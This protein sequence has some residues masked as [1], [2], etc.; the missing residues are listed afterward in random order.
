MRWAS[1]RIFDVGLWASQ[2]SDHLGSYIL[3]DHRIRTSGGHGILCFER[4]SRRWK[5]PDSLSI[6][7][8]V[9][10][11]LHTS[12]N[13]PAMDGVAA[14]TGVDLDIGQFGTPLVSSW[15]CWEIP[16]AL[17]FRSHSCGT[18]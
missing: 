1:S 15:L 16:S 11:E 18:G 17:Q 14:C 13:V 7:P 5:C 3:C 8:L 10:D 9:L 6:R 12:E 2:V 4:F